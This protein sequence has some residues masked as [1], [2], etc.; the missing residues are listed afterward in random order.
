MYLFRS[1]SCN[2]HLQKYVKVLPNLVYQKI[3]ILSSLSV[4]FIYVLCLKKCKQKCLIYHLPLYLPAGQTITAVNR[5]HSGVS[6]EQVKA[7]SVTIQIS[8][9]RSQ[10]CMFI[11]SNFRYDALFYI[12]YNFLELFYFLFIAKTKIM[13][14]SSVVSNNF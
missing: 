11:F 1:N 13:R 10:I 2:K 14:F 5:I 9:Y 3:L 6:R 12:K 7:E 8:L 4:N